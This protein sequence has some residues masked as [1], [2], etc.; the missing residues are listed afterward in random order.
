MVVMPCIVNKVR[1]VVIIA[2]VVGGGVER[3]ICER[4]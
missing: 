2:P 1:L 3:V 4:W